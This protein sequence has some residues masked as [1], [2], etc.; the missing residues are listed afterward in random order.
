MK[1][2]FVGLGA[3]GAGIVERLLAAGHDVTGWNRTRA[4]AEALVR[5]GMRVAETPRDAAAGTDVVFSML[6]NAA[7]VEAVLDGPDGILAGLPP[8]GVYAEMSTI[9]PDASRAL[10]ARVADAGAT[11]LDAPVSGSPATLAEGKLSVMVGGDEDAFERIRPVLVDMGPKVTRIGGNGD[12][13]LMKLA[14][15]LTLVVQVISFCESVALA[16]KGGVPREVA[17]DA[18]LKS[19]VGSPVLGYRGPF[20]LEGRMPDVAWSDIALQQKDM[21]LSLELARK[22]GVAVPLGASA[23]EFLNACRGLG[24]D[25]KDFA[26]VYEVYRR[27]GGMA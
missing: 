2:G 5:A 12:A 21:L 20:I 18:M 27:M 7:A 16:E 8:G 3:M 17:V 13:L 6:T 24:I 1:V 14:I 23:N 25:D 4:K 10:A 11:M 15:N 9:A 26:I 22:L 19:V